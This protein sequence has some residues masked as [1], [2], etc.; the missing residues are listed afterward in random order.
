[1]RFT[2]RIFTHDHLFNTQT[3]E[4]NLDGLDFL[5]QNILEV[6]FH[7]IDNLRS[8]FLCNRQVRLLTIVSLKTKNL[9]HK[10]GGFKANDW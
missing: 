4:T 3:A 5:L 8:I 10:S 9:W 7:H 6:N 1:M 2:P